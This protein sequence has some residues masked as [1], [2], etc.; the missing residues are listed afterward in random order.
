[1]TDSPARPTPE[2][3]RELAKEHYRLAEWEATDPYAG[4]GPE[5]EQATADMLTDYARLLGQTRE[6]CMCCRDQPCQDGCRCNK[7]NDDEP[8]G[9]R[10]HQP[11]V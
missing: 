7:S 5:I 10:G 4:R 9:C 6:P 2:Q 1:M 8:M 3:V 11:K